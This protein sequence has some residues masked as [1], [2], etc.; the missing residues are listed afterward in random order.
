MSACAPALDWRDTRLE[1]SAALLQFP[2][3]PTTQRR[4]V[5]LA[6]VHVNLAL[7]ACAAGGQTWGLAVADVGDPGL[8][9]PALAELTAAAAANLGA[10]AGQALTLR[11]PGATPND[12]S[13]RRRLAGRLPDGRSVQM[14]VAVFAHGTQVFQA[15]VLG[16]AVAD[17]A[18]ESFFS[19]LRIA[20]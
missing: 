14:Q 5:P 9:G 15:T 17:G 4:D 12:A 16:D 20:S 8:V 2:C 1:G 18:A 7:H 19:S 3:K 10:S 11:V 13:V 6:G